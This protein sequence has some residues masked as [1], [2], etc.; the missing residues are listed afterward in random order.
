VPGRQAISFPIDSVFDDGEGEAVVAFGAYGLDGGDVEARVGAQF[1]EE[2]SGAGDGGVGAVCF[3][4]VAFADD[5][6]AEDNGAG[7]GEFDGPVE[8]VG[9]VGLV[10]VEEDEVE[11]G[12]LFG[13]ELGEGFERRADAEVDEG[14]QA[15][16]VDVGGG[17]FGVFWVELE[18]DEFAGGGKSA[19]ETDGA[20]AAEGS[21]FEDA[22]CSGHAGE[23]VQE[24]ALGG[25]YVDGGEV[26]FGVG[27]YGLFEDRVG[28]DEGLGEVAVYGGE[29]GLIHEVK[30]KWGLGMWANDVWGWV[31]G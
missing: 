24:F 14:G 11:R 18:G 6:V 8:V 15:C 31:G 17:Y 29:E 2:G 7:A 13:V 30:D 22:F 20:V 10:G 28:G 3:E 27:F 25:A 26:G 1:F 4:D 16:A 21:D 19:G 12:G 5:V 9:V 23:K